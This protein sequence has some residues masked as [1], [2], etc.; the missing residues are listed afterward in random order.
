MPA[1]SNAFRPSALSSLLLAAFF[2]TSCTYTV[3]RVKDP[4]FAISL[5][6]ISG[7]LNGLVTATHFSVKGS[8]QTTNGKADSARLE[9]DVINGLHLPEDKQQL[10]TLGQ[11]IAATIHNALK[12][13]GE[14]GLY[15][16]RFVKRE[17]G[18]GFTKETSTAVTYRVS[19]L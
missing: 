11:S 6:S 17:S 1:F 10:G 16:V 14:Y 2:F 18:S 8:Q 4:E 19:Q 15:T 5:D 9:I 3:T 12:D 13:K 7:Q